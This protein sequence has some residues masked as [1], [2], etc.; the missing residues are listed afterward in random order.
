[1]SA[2][3]DGAFGPLLAEVGR[4]LDMPLP[5]RTRILLELQADLRDF[6]A[7]LVAQGVEPAEAR[8]RA[9]EALVPDTETAFALGRIHETAYRRFTRRFPP[10]RVLRLE[11]RALIACTGALLLVQGGLLVGT[12]LVAYASPFLWPV[13][14][15]GSLGAGLALWKAFELWVKRDHARMSR[16]VG[17]LLGL[18]VA[19]LIVGATGV[20]LD[21]SRLAATVEADPERLRSILPYWLIRDAGLLAVSLVLA[22]GG[23]LAWFVFRQWIIH[24]ETAHGEL[25]AGPHSPH[26]TPLEK[27]A[28]Q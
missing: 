21:L 17:G 1:V 26:P 8:R 2:G 22:L 24:V 7:Q 9:E 28:L 6:T 3:T 15:L 18:A 25:V 5:T 13:L 19:I 23:G 27:G 16:G 4:G 10:D 14:G 20:V 11:R 12:D